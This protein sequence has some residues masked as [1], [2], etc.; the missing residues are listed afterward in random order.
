MTESELYSAIKR[1]KLA[2]RSEHEIANELG[3][4]RGTLQSRCWVAQIS[5]ECP[6]I[7]EW[8]LEGKIT[9]ASCSHLH[10]ALTQGRLKEAWENY[11]NANSSLQPRKH[12]TQRIS[13]TEDELYSSVKR[14][15]LAGLSEQQI[16]TELNQHRSLI[17]PRGWVV[18]L[19]I[20]Q[21]D[22]EEWWLTG[23]IP[24]ESLNQLHTEFTQG[25]LTSAWEAYKDINGS[26]RSSSEIRKHITKEK[27][28]T[29]R[30][31]LLWVLRERETI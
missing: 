10:V 27:R 19:A 15:K 23:K 3:Q 31:A 21:P 29:V 8:W 25:R 6:D 4:N 22:I 30:N 17:Q 28:V 7:E 18:R 24:R 2:G 26:L 16:A 9:K 12:I 1:L 11:K 13:M 20:E 14:L 5:V